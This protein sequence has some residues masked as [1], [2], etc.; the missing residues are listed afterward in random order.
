MAE[1]L[2]Q[3]VKMYQQWLW[4]AK[5]PFSK[6]YINKKGHK[7]YQADGVIDRIL[8][9]QCATGQPLHVSSK[10]YERYLNHQFG[11]QGLPKLKKDNLE[12]HLSGIGTIY[13]VGSSSR[14]SQHLLACIDIDDKNKQGDALSLSTYLIAHCPVLGNSYVEQ[15][16]GG[17]G[18]HI[19]FIIS[20][21]GESHQSVNDILKRFGI[22]LSK[23]RIS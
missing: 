13:Y 17:Y 5:S 20:S 11:P 6:S 15:S 2:D 10:A 23:L 18:V 8:S 19:Y 22:Y 12:Y 3:L 1:N 14:H 16:L 4:G 7:V 21:L 9:T